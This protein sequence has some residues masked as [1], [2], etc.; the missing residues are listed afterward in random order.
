[1]SGRQLRPVT[2]ESL[3]GLA[4]DSIK[5]SILAGQFKPGA[6]LVE[7]RIASEL[8]ISRAPVREAM[9]RLGREGLTVDK[10]RRGTFVRIFDAKDIVDIYNTRI[11]IESA[12]VRLAVRAKVALEPIEKTIDALARAASTGDVTKTVDLEL[13]IHEQICEA[14]EN[15]YILM[16]FRSLTGPIRIALGMDDAAYADLQ[17]V[18]TEHLPLMEAMRSGN[19]DLAA[20]TIEAHIVSTVGSVLERLGGNPDELLT[21]RRSHK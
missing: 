16:S 18:A 20:T 11:A 17:D 19:A 4:Y 9:S 3:V 8:E 13:R 12:A 21:P 10:P 1:M 15:P 14:S 7:N 5:R 2:P 6:H